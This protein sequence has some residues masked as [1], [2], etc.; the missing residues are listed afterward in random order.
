[1]RRSGL[2][3]PR[4]VVSG[5]EIGR[6][7]L[8]IAGL[9][10]VV[11]GAGL[12][13]RDPWPADEPRFALVAQDMVRSGQW[14]FPSIGGDLY[15]DKPPFF[16]WLIAAFYALTGSL[17]VAFLVPSLLAGIGSTLLV[18]D[19]AR[20][21]WDRR[22][23]LW[24]ALALLFS[25]QFSMQAHLAQI[26]GVLCFLTTLSLYGL[27][28]HLLLGD[29]WKWYALGGFAAGIGVITKG[30]GFLP[31]A[32]L[33]PYVLARRYRWPLP[34]LEREGSRWL[35]ALGTFALAIALWLVPM[36]IAVAASGDPRHAGYRDEILFHQTM[37]RYASAWHHQKPFYYYFMVM[38]GLW[39]PLI[40]A[41]PWLVAR[42]RE[43]W[44]ERDTRVFLLLAWVVLVLLFFSA[45]PGKRGVYILPALPALALCAGPWLRG[46]AQRRDVQRTV[47][48]VALGIVIVCGVAFV[49]LTWITPEKAKA[50]EAS[51][52]IRTFVPLA[53]VSLLGA[54]VLRIC[55]LERAPQAWAAVLGILWF[56][57]GW[58]LM[59]QMNGT[60]SARDFIAHVEQVADPDL[61]LGLLEYK[62]QFLLYLSRPSVNF[63]HARWRE[64]PQETFDAARWLSEG[65]QRQLLI[66]DDQL[67]PC[68][69]IASVRVEVGESSRDKWWLVRGPV[70]PEC[71]R[72][73]DPKRALLYSGAP[74]RRR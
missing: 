27:C 57:G 3:L 13:M 72:Q 10:L 6:D 56:V 22:I 54:I 24:T 46:L 64:Q 73:G 11:L 23:G 9:G 34:A 70:D 29:G 63:G 31:L 7:V 74:Q 59:P 58:W 66:P 55:G 12:G 44:R 42:W 60:R 49:A 1:M 68:F 47:F 18:Y 17:R 35:I 14:L 51:T 40:L 41:V 39:L 25:V 32:I 65:S 5:R 71:A 69:A 45:S 2:E 15:P 52:G 28:R 4:E 50:I 48:G 19:L 67:K 16:F 36:L 38:L 8:L 61:E 30:V 43:R 26:D 37:T 33:I 21:L 62:E 53:V 20:R